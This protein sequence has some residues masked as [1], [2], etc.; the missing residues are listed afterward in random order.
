MTS[1]ITRYQILPASWKDVGELRQVEKACFQDDAWPLLDLLGV[2]T[3]P[4]VV[5]LKAVVDGVM[6]G[7]VAGEPRP[8]PGI[9]WIT[10]IGVLPQYRRLGIGTALL[11]AA[12][13]Q[14]GMPRVRLTMRRSNTVAQALYQKEGYHQVEVWPR[15]Y[16]G[17]ED[18][19]VF[20]KER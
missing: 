15:Y 13:E 14:M 5:R 12:E 10:T 20:E 8:G 4:G 16:A 6:A 9:G 19:V 17:G 7:F 11:A 1:Q 3:M 2:L 18:G